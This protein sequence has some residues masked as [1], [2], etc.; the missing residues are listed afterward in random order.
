MSVPVRVS[1]PL[2]RVVAGVLVAGLV[3]T[4]GCSWFRRGDALYAN[5]PANR[6][7]EVPPALELPR[8]DAT[9]ASA[10]ASG[11]AP[12][13][14]G[15]AVAGAAVAP[16]A[17]TGGFIVPGSRDAVFDRVGEELAKV[18]GVAVVSRAQLLGAF[19][20]TYQGSS[21]LVRVG[22][23]ETG[24]TVAAVDPRGMPASGEAPARLMAQLKA[25]LGGN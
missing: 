9:T 24:S 21:F 14:T 13:A 25:A 5:D 6:P 3:A 15:T 4:S 7:L 8:A 11:T 23:A 1:A 20:V 19:D 10:A 16:A 12:A 22:A 18:P 17:A 2:S